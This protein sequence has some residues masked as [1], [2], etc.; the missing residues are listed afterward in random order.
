MIEPP[1]VDMSLDISP[2]PRKHD[3]IRKEG[4]PLSD[5]DIGNRMLF[6]RWCNALVLQAVLNMRKRR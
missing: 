5:W 6:D 2:D 1:G 4:Y 3:D